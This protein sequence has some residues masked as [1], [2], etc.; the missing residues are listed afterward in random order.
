MIFRKDARLKDVFLSQVPMPEGKTT[1]HRVSIADI[2]EWPQGG[3]T[4]MEIY[5][6]ADNR[7]TAYSLRNICGLACKPTSG[8]GQDEQEVMVN[9]GNGF[10]R[11]Q[12]YV[13]V[14]L[15]VLMVQS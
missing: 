12:A 13:E 7:R 1:F 10:G 6:P 2:P 5:V 8:C 14:S 4:M 3:I 15:I 9:Y 11:L